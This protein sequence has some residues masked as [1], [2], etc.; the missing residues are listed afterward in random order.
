MPQALDPSAQDLP[1]LLPTLER[2]RT[3]ALVARD[4]V[5]ARA[6]HAADYE[7]VTPGGTRLSGERYLGRIAAGELVY[8]RWDC[9][10]MA[11]RT[12]PQLVLLRYTATLQFPGGEPFDCWHLDAWQL[13]D[14]AWQAAW[15]Q[16]TAIRP[17]Q[18]GPAAP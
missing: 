17:A 4:M 9:G 10:P 12:T 13:L 1:T 5:R 3:Q 6:L 16:A 18:P 2:Q 11:V 15:S 14:G 7:L 8:Q